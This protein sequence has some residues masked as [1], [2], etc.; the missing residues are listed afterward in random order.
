MQ[1][2]AMQCS[3]ENVGYVVSDG[4]VDEMRYRSAPHGTLITHPGSWYSTWTKPQE[5]ELLQHQHAL[6]YSSSL[7]SHYVRFLR[8]RSTRRAEAWSVNFQ[9]APIGLGLHVT[10]MQLRYLRQTQLLDSSQ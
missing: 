1:C 9:S 10:K 4:G 2:D 5:S 8:Q 3:L 7:R 6:H